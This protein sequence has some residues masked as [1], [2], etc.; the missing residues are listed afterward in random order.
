MALDAGSPFEVDGLL[1]RDLL[2]AKAPIVRWSEFDGSVQLAVE[3]WVWERLPFAC[4]RELRYEG[5][6][7][8]EFYGLRESPFDLAPNP[9]FLYFSPRHREAF[10]HL[11]YGLRERKGFVQ[12]T[13][14]VA[15]RPYAGLCCMSWGRVLRLR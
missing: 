1:F 2:Q 9:R 12:L 10:N 3:V 8:L 11:I 5:G 14:E 6:V 4:W 13:G 7:Y 15:R